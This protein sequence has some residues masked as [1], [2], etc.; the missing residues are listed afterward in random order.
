VAPG[1]RA[2]AEPPLEVT[3]ASKA[4]EEEDLNGN[5]EVLGPLLDKN[6]NRRQVAKQERKDNEYSNKEPNG[7]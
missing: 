4:K 1:Y 6:S 7:S 3:N 2:I 5:K